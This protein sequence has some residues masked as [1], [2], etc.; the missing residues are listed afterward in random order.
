MRAEQLYWIILFTVSAVHIGL[1]YYVFN[2]HFSIWIMA[3]ILIAGVCLFYKRGKALITELGWRLHAL[4][5]VVQAIIA[6][7]A[8]TLKAEWLWL[9]SFLLFWGIEFIRNMVT[10]ELSEVRRELAET[11]RER[12]KM[13]ETFRTVRSER[14]DFLKHIAAIHYMVEKNEFKEAAAYLN[15]LVDGY[16]ETNLSIKGESGA[17]AAVLH[18]HYMKAQKESIEVIY[19][20]DVPIS[21]MPVPDKELVALVGNLLENSLEA[22]LEWQKAYQQQAFI[23]LNLVKRS[24]L[25]ILTLRN[26]TM[27][28]PA[29][30][31]DRLY[32]QFGNSTKAG[33]DRGIGTKVIY[34][35]V[36]KHQGVLDFVY[37]EEE[38]TVKIKLPAIR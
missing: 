17:V 31:L 27:P 26:R 9:V 25:Y 15:V 16:K 33:S 28:I 13:N 1:F 3:L 30:I 8:L 22:C 36:K 12:E 6:A 24:G 11:D 4:F 10:V 5:W 38:F 29:K 7:V 34:E 32:I 19:D 37:K 14:H 21:V 35:I 20:L 18:Q 23:T 2:W